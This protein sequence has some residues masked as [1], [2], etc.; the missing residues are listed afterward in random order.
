MTPEER[1]ISSVLSYSSPHH[2]EL[3][4]IIYH[5]DAKWPFSVLAIPRGVP[6]TVPTLPF[7]PR[8]GYGSLRSGRRRRSR[9]RAESGRNGGRRWWILP[10]FAIGSQ[11]NKTRHSFACPPSSNN[12]SSL[13]CCA[14]L[15]APPIWISLC[16]PTKLHGPFATRKLNA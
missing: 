4:A 12:R 14:A 5:T 2:H 6:H 3:V 10:F 1:D 8:S 16:G 11:Y 9:S 13:M 15:P 7:I